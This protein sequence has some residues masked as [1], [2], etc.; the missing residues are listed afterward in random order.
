MNYAEGIILSSAARREAD[1]V[2]KIYTKELGLVD[3]QAKSVKKAQAK[4][5]FN[6]QP[7][8]RA[9]IYFVPARYLPIIVDS[10]IE[11][12][13]PVLKQDLARLKLAGAVGHVLKNVFEPRVPD[14][15]S[16][17]KISEYFDS[18]NN[19]QLD[20]DKISNLTCLMCYQLL[21]LGGFDPELVRCTVCLKPIFRGRLNISL[22]NGGLV[23]AACAYTEV[24]LSVNR[25]VLYLVNDMK[26]TD[27]RAVLS[28]NL[29][30]ATWDDFRKLTQ[31]FFQYYFGLDIGELI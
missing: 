8:N 18:L 23:H 11:N 31:F 24:S 16:W 17:Q 15:R 21:G 14:Y 4:L 6:L 1:A 10:K 7:F 3:F 29:N 19:P 20:S 22:I 27:P 9:L 12:D 25:E 5:K 2:F 30:S 26:K 28:Q 13:F